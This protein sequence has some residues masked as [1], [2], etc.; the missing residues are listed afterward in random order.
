MGLRGPAPLPSAINIANGNPSRRPINKLEP[1]VP[2]G[3]PEMPPGMSPAAKRRWKQLME[4]LGKLR[5][6]ALSDGISLA[7]FAR[8]IAE[9]DEIEKTI[10]KQGRVI[11]NPKTGQ[12]HA[13]PLLNLKTQ[14]DTQ[15]YSWV[16]EFYG[17]PSSRS[18]AQMPPEDKRASVIEEMTA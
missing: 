5:V 7:E 15:I 18:R 8:K 4:Y 2:I 13:H 9:R 1:K 17:S 16:K 10:K 11:T 12:P 3:E 6:V 14:M